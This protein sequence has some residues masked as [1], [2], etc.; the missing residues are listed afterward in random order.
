[1]QQPIKTCTKIND[2]TDIHKV[3]ILEDAGERK[4]DI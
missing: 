1:M 3:H 4:R 2:K